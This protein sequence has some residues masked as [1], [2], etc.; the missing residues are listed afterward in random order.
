[1]AGLFYFALVAMGSS[2][3]VEN[4]CPTSTIVQ[5]LEDG[6]ASLVV[7]DGLVKAAL[8]APSEPKVVKRHGLDPLVL[9]TSSGA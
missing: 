2:K 1:L 7:L 4:P 3:V 5:L 6:K 8:L 9:G